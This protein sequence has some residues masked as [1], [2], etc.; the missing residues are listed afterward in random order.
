MLRQTGPF[1]TTQRDVDHSPPLFVGLDDDPS[2]MIVL[3]TLCLSTVSQET[4]SE[5]GAPKDY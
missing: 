4:G 5:I 3:L 1:Q 2:A